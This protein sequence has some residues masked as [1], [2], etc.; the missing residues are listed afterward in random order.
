MKTL[1]DLLNEGS[2]K[3]Q[4]RV[5]KLVK[6]LKAKL[7]VNTRPYYE[8]RVEAPKGYH[9]ADGVHEFVEAQ[10]GGFSV[11][12]LW[13]DVYDRMQDGTEKCTEECDWH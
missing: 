13:K 1:N 2:S 4:Q 3:Y 10:E 7:E 8:V 11:D 12:E 9:W 6:K 5:K